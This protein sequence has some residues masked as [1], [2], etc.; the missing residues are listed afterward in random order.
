MLKCHVRGDGLVGGGEGRTVLCAGCVDYVMVREGDGA[1]VEEVVISCLKGGAGALSLP[2]LAPVA[3]AG[4][5]HQRCAWGCRDM[6]SWSIRSRNAC[7]DR[8]RDG[9]LNVYLKDIG[10]GLRWDLL[11]G[12]AY[13][14]ILYLPNLTRGIGSS[15]ELGWTLAF[16]FF[17][18][19][20]LMLCSLPL[21]MRLAGGLLLLLLVVLSFALTFVCFGL[22]ASLLCSPGGQGQGLVR[23]RLRPE[24]RSQACLSK[25]HQH[26]SMES[27]ELP[28]LPLRDLVVLFGRLGAHI[29]REGVE[30]R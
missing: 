29:L 15:P 2:P 14:A 9:D 26:G 13:R 6:Q 27:S 16:A 22:V 3:T 23:G 5:A 28:D 10:L 7:F 12:K 8:T 24:P 20:E 21:Y 18:I 19:C 11:R 30:G 25:S 17:R 4:G 1:G